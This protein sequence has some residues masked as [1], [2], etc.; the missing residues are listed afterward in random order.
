MTADEVEYDDRSDEED[1]YI[2]IQQAQQFAAIPFAQKKYS[3]K[4]LVNLCVR[5]VLS[6]AML[7]HQ[8][9]T[10]DYDSGGVE[11][12]ILKYLEQ[13]ISQQVLVSAMQSGFG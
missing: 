9:R 13:Q 3:V 1:D 10:T 8:A 4:P 7:G 2:S 6:Q 11:L 5:E 12:P